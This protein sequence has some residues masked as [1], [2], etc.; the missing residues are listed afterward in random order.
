VQPDLGIRRQCA[1]LG[2][3][4]A[5]Y[6]Y[7]PVPEEP[8]KLELMRHIDVQ[9]LKTP[10]R[11]WPKMTAALRAQGY[12]VN[13]K[14]VRHGLD[15]YFQFYNL[16][17]P[18]QSLDYRTPAEVQYAAYYCPVCLCTCHRD[19]E[20][21]LRAPAVR[22]GDMAAGNALRNACATEAC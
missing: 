20:R 7:E 5:S 4:R 10:F 16:E 8:L 13:G 19:C 18:H 6:R 11:G 15:G 12:P 3:N 14:R 1:L 17:R 22:Q 2:L 9:Y 21:S